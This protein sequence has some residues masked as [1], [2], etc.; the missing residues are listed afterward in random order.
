MLIVMTL[1][2][3]TALPATCQMV[4]ANR[5]NKTKSRDKWRDFTKRDLHQSPGH[6]ISTEADQFEEC[7]GVAGVCA[8]G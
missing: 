6:L 5:G 8:T 2:Q 4:W 1:Q 3:C 7:L